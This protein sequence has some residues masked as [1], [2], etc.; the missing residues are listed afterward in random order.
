MA[1]C[2][3]QFQNFTTAQAAVTDAAGA[4]DEA[5]AA[6]A[7]AQSDLESKATAASAAYQAWLECIV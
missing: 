5:A 7:L 4:R 3:T 6:L 1:D 2:S